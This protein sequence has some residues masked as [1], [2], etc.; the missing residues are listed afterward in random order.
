L[1]GAKKNKGKGINSQAIVYENGLRIWRA[2]MATKWKNTETLFKIV[3]MAVL[4]MLMWVGRDYPEKSRLFPS[5]IFG[6]TILLILGS[7]LQ[8]LLKAKRNLRKEESEAQPSP[9]S[10]IREEKLRMIRELEEKGAEDAGY[11]LLEESLRRKRLRESVIIILVS[12]GISYV[13][14]FLFAVPFY[15]IAFGILHGKKGH[16]LRY[17][18]VAAGTTVVIYLFFTTL[19]EVPLLKGLF[20]G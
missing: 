4:L 18:A 17:I 15:F 1:R 6:I 2:A 8:D 14:G 13:G 9:P 20:W 5:I 16:T 3:V 12:L 19:M 7:F 11:E 10:D